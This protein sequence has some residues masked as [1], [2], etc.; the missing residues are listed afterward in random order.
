[1]ETEVLVSEIE[2]A[3]QR[4]SDA[5]I[6]DQKKEFVDNV[7]PLLKLIVQSHGVRLDQAEGALGELI[8]GSES[9]ITPE[10][11]DRIRGSLALGIELATAVLAT[12]NAGH[13]D[14]KLV[15]LARAYHEAATITTQVVEE[16]TM[17]DDD[18]E[19][20]DEGESEPAPAPAE[21]S[22]IA[23]AVA[24]PPVEEVTL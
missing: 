8:Q 12:T 14:N 24:E 3:Q 17:Y 21:A 23:E 9:I 13:D 2:R 20:D 6:I 16:Y 15:A 18:D 10:L 1:M 4:L 22:P 5:P 19:D 11:G 7:Y